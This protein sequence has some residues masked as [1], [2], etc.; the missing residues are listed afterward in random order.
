MLTPRG[1]L[2]TLLAVAALY[3]AMRWQRRVAS[4]S[5]SA[6]AEI[7]GTFPV[8]GQYPGE[9][10]PGGNAVRS[11]G[12]WGGSDEN[13]GSVRIGP[14]PAPATITFAVGGYP[15]R[16]GNRILLERLDSGERLPLPAADV[17]ERW[18]IVRHE[19]PSAWRGQRVSLVAID[20][21]KDLGGWIALSEPI[22]GGSNSLL[23]GFI[24]WA[25]NGLI[26]GALWW[27]ALGFVSTRAWAPPHWQPL[28]AA[29]CVAV[30]GYLLFWLYFA[31]STAGKVGSVM[32]IVW[33][34]LSLLRGRTRQAP[35]EADARAVAPLFVAVGF[36]YVGLLFLFPSSREFYNLTANRFAENLPGDNTLPH[37]VASAL[38]R[39][40]T[41]RH[42]GADWLSSDRP[43]LQSGWM[44]LTWPVTAALRLDERSAGGTAAM[45][46]QSLWIAA[47]FGLFRTLHVSLARARAWVLVLAF[48]GFFLLNT[49]YTWPKLSAAAFMCGAF[50]IGLL[51]SREAGSVVASRRT[52]ILASCVLVALAWLSHGG[53]AFSVLGALPWIVARLFRGEIRTWIFGGL[54]FATFAVPWMA[55][56][57]FYD[58]PGNRLLKMHLGGQ[59]AKDERGTWQTIRD[60]YVSRPWE[61]IVRS[62]AENLRFQLG[63]RWSL[64]ADFTRGPAAQRAADEFFHSSRTLAWWVLGAALLPVTLLRARPRS[65]FLR[66]GRTQLHLML[67]TLATLVVWCLLMHR[68]AV[69]HQGSYA[70]LLTLF[71]L[72][73]TW[74]EFAGRLVIFGFAVVQAA[75]FATTWA[76]ANSLVRGSPQPFAVLLIAAALFGFAAIW[77]T[78]ARGT[79]TDSAETAQA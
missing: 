7:V 75:S 9:P 25:I 58:P 3:G 45:W 33:S 12:S 30:A 47:A 78:A 56:Q 6:Q 8:G 28:I 44:L 43:P 55:Y 11:W 16:A 10:L 21:A 57:K 77:W 46:F 68:N 72:A 17:G 53:A 41:L 60:A 26:L 24:A 54:L 74:M 50:V 37:N 2:F 22:S 59:D 49:V 19:V 69:V 20:A 70:V 52:E 71:V 40:E 64:L 1:V 51:P 14:F 73:S 42:P 18:T 65:A 13:T 23:E 29:A 62:K 34:I 76:G 15:S 79:A 48:S 36:F 32:L 38:Y 66:A 35:I 67:W 31:N 39:G 4:L 27:A 63:I 61:E 5:P